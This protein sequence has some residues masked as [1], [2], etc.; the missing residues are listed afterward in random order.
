MLQGKKHLELFFKKFIGL[1][2]I[3][4]IL[5]SISCTNNPIV[6]TDLNTY[7]ENVGSRSYFVF[8]PE[9]PDRK[10]F[11]EKCY[12]REF[13]KFCFE[14]FLKVKYNE[15]EFL[16]EI[17]RLENLVY[18]DESRGIE[19]GMVKDKNSVLFNT[20]TYVS[21]YTPIAEDFGYASIYYESKEIVYVHINQLSIKNISIEKKYLPKI[22]N[23]EDSFYAEYSYSMYSDYTTRWL[24]EE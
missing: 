17:D 19:K 24:D 15:K 4:I 6:I 21:R 22:F 2:L 16:E 7:L 12:R 1:V 5:L 10:G 14:V 18:V 9:C 23:N 20:F 8:F 13:S 11:V 3:I